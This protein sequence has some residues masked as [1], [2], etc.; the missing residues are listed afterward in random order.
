MDP[1]LVWWPVLLAALPKVGHI[2]QH[3]GF[4]VGR[5][6]KEL[7]RAARGIYKGGCARSTLRCRDQCSNMFACIAVHIVTQYQFQG[8]TCADWFR[9]PDSRIFTQG[10]SK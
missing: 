4:D 7:E 6:A 3:S 10:L 1:C 9:G 8:C 2:D 5:G